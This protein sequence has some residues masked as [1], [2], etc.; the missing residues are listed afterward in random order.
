LVRLEDRGGEQLVVLDLSADATNRLA[1][2]TGASIG[3]WMVIALNG[4]EI[5]SNIVTT[6]NQS[7]VLLQAKNLR[8][9]DL[10]RAR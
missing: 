2:A 5:A 4:E 9:S 8:P 7:R 3:D 10:C 1:K 6:V